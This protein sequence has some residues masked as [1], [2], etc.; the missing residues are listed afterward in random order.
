M[1]FCTK[2]CFREISLGVVHAAEFPFLGDDLIGTV[3]VAGIEVA[4][5]DGDQ[6]VGKSFEDH[7]IL[8]SEHVC[9]RIG[10]RTQPEMNRTIPLVVGEEVQKS[11]GLFVRSVSLGRISDRDVKGVFQVRSLFR[12]NNAVFDRIFL[13]YRNG[14]L[15]SR[16]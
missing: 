14:N 4:D 8:Q 2:I 9:L 15:V 5:L 13:V 11:K 12:A 3:A 1:N 16:Q 6:F 7:V 10:L